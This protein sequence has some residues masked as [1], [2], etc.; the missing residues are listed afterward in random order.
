M[1]MHSQLREILHMIEAIKV[2]MHD[3]L[4][5]IR[6]SHQNSQWSLALLQERCLMAHI[7]NEYH[8]EVYG[9]YDLE[10]DCDDWYM[11]SCH[12]W[13]ENH[14]HILFDDYNLPLV[15]NINVTHQE[16]VMITSCCRK[17][18]LQTGRLPQRA[19]P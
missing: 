10:D 12:L 11:D 3:Y 8:Q 16:L 15:E 4:Q 5:G 17:I 7:M 6:Y 2:D 19:R 18:S 14:F 9:W 1:D 13:N